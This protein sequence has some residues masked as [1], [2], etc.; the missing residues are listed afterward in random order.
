MSIILAQYVGMNCGLMIMNMKA[1]RSERRKLKKR[2]KEL[3]MQFAK[4]NICMYRLKK[5][6]FVCFFFHMKLC[7]RLHLYIVG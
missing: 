5:A 2:G 6:L 7:C 3:Q 4:V 1:E